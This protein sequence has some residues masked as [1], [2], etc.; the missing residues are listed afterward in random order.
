MQEYMK[1]LLDDA[2]FVLENHK[3][4]TELHKQLSNLFNRRAPNGKSPFSLNEKLRKN[5]GNSS[6]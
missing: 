2:R 5:E 3:E 1:D 6:N 4:N